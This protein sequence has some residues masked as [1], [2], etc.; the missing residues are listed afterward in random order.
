MSAPT[1][2]RLVRV[3]GVTSAV[4]GARLV[5]ARIAHSGMAIAAASASRPMRG[6]PTGP[7]GTFPLSPPSLEVE[8]SRPQG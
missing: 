5:W 1:R 2:L 7:N 8:A 4:L 6:D 3:L